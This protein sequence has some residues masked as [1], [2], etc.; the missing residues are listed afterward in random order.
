MIDV[1]ATLC[2]LEA[3]GTCA[4]RVVPVGAET[5]PEA[6]AAAAGRLEAWRKAYIV[7]DVRCGALKGPPLDF[8]EVRPGLFVH[9]GHIGLAEAENGGDIA[10]IAFVVGERGVAVVDAGGSRALGEAVV[11]AVRAVTDRPI[12]L[13]I[14][15]HF[16]PDHVFGGTALVDAGAEILAHE[17]LPDALWRG[18]TASWSREGVK[19]ARASSAARC[20]TWTAPLMRASSLI[21]AGGFWSLRL[22]PLHIPRPT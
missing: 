11:A 19:S 14:L 18:P 6:E 22:G 17:R 16:H 12:R 15:T 10:N 1:L 2:L 9:R 8:V 7:M 4:A 20:R 3:H 13:L 5:C 21:S